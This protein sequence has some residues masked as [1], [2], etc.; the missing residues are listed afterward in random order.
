MLRRESLSEEES[1]A[2]LS[3]S[4]STKAAAG[5]AAGAPAPGVGAGHC[6]GGGQDTPTPGKRRHLHKRHQHH[7]RS[8]RLSPEGRER[9]FP[10]TRVGH[11]QSSSPPPPP[12][13]HQHL[14]VDSAA[15]E[16]DSEESV[17]TMG[18]GDERFFPHQP[19][20]GSGSGGG[21]GGGGGAA[22]PG[23]GSR[24]GGRGGLGQTADFHYT[25]QPTSEHHFRPSQVHQARVLRQD[26]PYQ[27]I[28]QQGTA[29]ATAGY[30]SPHVTQ[31]G[32]RVRSGQRES[33]YLEDGRGSRNKSSPYHHAAARV[34]AAA[35]ARD[36]QQP[37]F[38]RQQQQRHHLQQQYEAEQFGLQHISDSRSDLLE[39]DHN[40]IYNFGNAT[41]GF[42][43]CDGKFIPI[44]LPPAAAS[45]AAAQS[46]DIVPSAADYRRAAATHG[47][48][49]RRSKRSSLSTDSGGGYGSCCPR[50]AHGGRSGRSSGVGSAAPM[51]AT[52]RMRPKK[53]GRQGAGSGGSSG[54]GGGG[55]GGGVGDNYGRN[56][57]AATSVYADDSRS[58]AGFTDDDFL[59]P[60]PPHG[61]HEALLVTPGGGSGGARI[62]SRSTDRN[63][64][65]HHHHHH[66]HE[67]SGGGGGAID[68][69]PLQLMGNAAAAMQ[70]MH[71]ASTSDQFLHEREPPDGKEKPEPACK[72]GGQK[73]EGNAGAMATL[74]RKSSKC[75]L[76][77]QRAAV[78]VVTGQPSSSSEAASMS[79]AES[80]GVIGKGDSAASAA[81]LVGGG[82][83]NRDSLSGAVMKDVVFQMEHSGGGGNVGADQLDVDVAAYSSGKDW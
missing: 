24:C 10:A 39:H 7:R 17:S 43:S 25:L 51:Y 3:S 54:G 37:D 47:T 59:L 81:A 52:L 41:T 12:P 46:Y 48:L 35:A 75:D 11:Q 13:P 8:S 67:L 1:E 18:A 38:Y 6:G 68:D 71:L 50:D 56:Q 72:A 29:T 42:I 49:G 57:F 45:A 34:A 30:Q 28:T 36:P 22:P 21:G 14:G 16:R 64:H 44:P 60:P 66:Q 55:G 5:A 61:H 58:L 63:L 77:D 23:S 32:S 15:P 4:L 83:G 27:N 20:P 26:P 9:E 76:L 79:G 62:M 73:M 19:Q 31:G 40:A 78:S 69:D 53:D 70:P 82:G 74:S 33:Y 2:G 80:T 65:H